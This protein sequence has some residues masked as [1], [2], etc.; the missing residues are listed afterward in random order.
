[1]RSV[2]HANYAAVVAVRVVYLVVGHVWLDLIS[3]WLGHA[4]GQVTLRVYLAIVGGDRG[5]EVVRG[6]AA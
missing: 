5:K 3:E 1:M 6:Q 2:G 4:N